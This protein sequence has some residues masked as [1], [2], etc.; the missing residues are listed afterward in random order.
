MGA[1][2]GAARLWG[3]GVGGWAVMGVRVRVCLWG[4]EISYGV[5]LVD[6]VQMVLKSSSNPWGLRVLLGC[7]SAVLGVL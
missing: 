7:A 2:K 5:L 1:F 6:Y 3:L 4:G